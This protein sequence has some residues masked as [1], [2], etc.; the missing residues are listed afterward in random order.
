VNPFKSNGGSGT[1]THC[2][3]SSVA[4]ASSL[5]PHVQPTNVALTTLLHPSKHAAAPGPGV[6]HTGP[7]NAWLTCPSNPTHYSTEEVQSLDLVCELLTE[8]L[9]EKIKDRKQPLPTS[10]VKSYTYQLLKALEH[11]H[12]NGIFHRDVKPENI[13]LDS[14]TDTLKLADFGSCRG[15]YSKVRCLSSLSHLTSRAMS[16]ADRWTNDRLLDR[17]VYGGTGCRF[18]LETRLAVRLYATA[19]RCAALSPRLTLRPS[20]RLHSTAGAVH[21]VHFHAL[22]PRPR[23]PA[24]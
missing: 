19:R 22:V 20:S 8:N 7:P 6:C 16:M 9:Y 10:L 18:H 1:A 12:R 21:R 13:L 17:A 5:P 15:I 14:T 2:S 24:H 23:M 11:M 4:V 3:R